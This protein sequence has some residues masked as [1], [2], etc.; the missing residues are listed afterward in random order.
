MA[1]T[2][3]NRRKNPCVVKKLEL[4]SKGALR[5]LCTTESSLSE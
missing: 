2:S 3:S 5:E 4:L 1:Y